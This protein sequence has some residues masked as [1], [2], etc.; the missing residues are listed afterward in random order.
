VCLNVTEPSHGSPPGKTVYAVDRMY[1]ETQRRNATRLER[2]GMKIY[3][4]D[5]RS[6]AR[7]WQVDV[8]EHVVCRTEQHVVLLCGWLVWCDGAAGGAILRKLDHQQGMIVPGMLAT[9]N[10]NIMECC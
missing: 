9:V 6:G 7:C 5:L 8:V 3:H 2:D 4:F 1:I 10:I